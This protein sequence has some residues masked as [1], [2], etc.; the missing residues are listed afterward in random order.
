MLPAALRR[1]ACHRALQDLKERLLYSLARYITGDGYILG[2]LGDLVYLVNIYDSILRFADI[3]ICRLDQLQ[4]DILHILT[5][6]SGLCQG[7]SVCDGKRHVQHLCKGLSQVGL[8]GTGG[9]QQQDI[10]LL[11]IHIQVLPGGDTF[12][13]IIYGY[14]QDFLGCILSNDIIVQ[15]RLDLLWFE[16]VN[17]VQIRSALLVLIKFFLQ[18]LRTKINTFITNVNIVG[19]GDQLFHLIL[20]L[21]AE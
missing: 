20:A 2:F 18:N 4:Q 15:E 17:A 19:P 11:Y 1:N 10:A 9:A 13:V 16:Q 12:I 6:I 7:C 5:H 8:A 3:V 21:S 14:R